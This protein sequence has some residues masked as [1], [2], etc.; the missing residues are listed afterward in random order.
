M[1]PTNEPVNR[2]T[3]VVANGRVGLL[4]IYGARPD[5]NTGV[6]RSDRRRCVAVDLSTVGGETPALH[7][8]MASDD[9]WVQCRT[10]TFEDELTEL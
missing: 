8:A 9:E 2:P 7:G 4:L 10:S 3:V 1:R 6:R 5:V